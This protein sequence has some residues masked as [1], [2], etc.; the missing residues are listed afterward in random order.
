VQNQEKQQMMDKITEQYYDDLLEMFNSDA[1]KTFNEDIS[2][3]YE[4]LLESSPTACET[5]DLWQYRRGQLEILNY[6]N[7]YEAVMINASEELS[8]DVH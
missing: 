4:S 2:L 7:N 3:M 5:N 8:K 1:W 6:I